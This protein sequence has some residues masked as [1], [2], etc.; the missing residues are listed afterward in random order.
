MLFGV[1]KTIEYHP[2]K[3]EL[4]KYGT[5]KWCK[6]NPDTRNP[7]AQFGQ[8]E[9]DEI[10]DRPAL[11]A[12]FK[13]NSIQAKEKES[14]N[15]QNKTSRKSS[16]PNANHITLPSKHINM[17]KNPSFHF[18][19]SDAYGEHIEKYILDEKS[20]SFLKIKDA[21]TFELTTTYPGL[22]VGSGYMHPKLKSKD[23]FQL[24]F[25]FDHTTGLPIISGSSIKGLIRS[26]FPSDTKDSEG[27]YTDKYH[28]E[29]KQYLNEE[30]GLIYSE[31]LMDKLFESSETVF[32]DAF[33]VKTENDGHIFGSDYVTSHYSD[34]P[35]G[36][37]KEPNPVKFLKVLPKVT[38][39]FQFKVDEEYLDFFKKVLLDFGIGAK[40]NVGY[41]KFTA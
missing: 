12:F 23:D 20:I 1:P 21:N 41:G 17:I 31:K 32:Y 36:M 5:L 19:K 15:T 33:I 34:E 35:E 22:L 26:V 39:A 40:T 2:L 27:R 16:T 37:F 18:Y 6:L 8:V 3:E 4:Q 14:N 25:F 13:K 11:D 10:L 7:N 29:K 28:E 9:Y 30:Y 24:G 38:F